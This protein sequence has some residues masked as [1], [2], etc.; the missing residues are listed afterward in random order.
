MYFNYKDFSIY[1]EKHGNSYKSI[2]I[3][4]G[5]GNTRNTFYNMIDYFKSEYSV[6]ILDYPGFGLSKSIHRELDIFDYTYVIYPSFT[7]KKI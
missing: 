4:P 3:L 2:L 1:Y 5:W 6:Y 7:V